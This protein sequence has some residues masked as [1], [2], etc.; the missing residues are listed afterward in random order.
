M[1]INIENNK[2]RES[3]NVE[4]LGII[5]NKY[6]KFDKYLNEICSK[7]NKNL[8]VLSR[9][10]SFLS[11]K[12]RRISFKSFIE[13][14][15]KYCALNWIFC[16]RKSNNKINRLHER[17]LRIVNNDHESIYEE[18]LSHNNCFSIHDQNMY[19]WLLKYT[20]LIIICQ[21]EI[22]KVRFIL[23]ISIPYI[24]L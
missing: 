13:S 1:F 3:K 6:L 23:R 18:V 11:A 19:F 20:K 4:I 14:Q 22:S 5:I 10:Q 16:R 15:F 7:A 21:W 17:S 9:M 2:I 8:N 12:K 24:S